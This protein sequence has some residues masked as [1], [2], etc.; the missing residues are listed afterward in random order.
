MT[1]R[2]NLLVLR[3][4]DKLAINKTSFDHV[5]N[6]GFLLSLNFYGRFL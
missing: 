6:M 3:V 1:H 2:K 5:R 4:L